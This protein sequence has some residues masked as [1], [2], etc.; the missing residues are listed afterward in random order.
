MVETTTIRETPQDPE[1]PTGVRQGRT[2][3]V[4]RYVLSI[5]LALAIVAMIIVFMV[6]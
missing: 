1:S 6:S 2:L 4:M 5:S 3:G